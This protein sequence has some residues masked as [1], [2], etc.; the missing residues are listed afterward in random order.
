MKKKKNSG[1]ALGY[2]HGFSKTEQERLVNQAKLL[3]RFVFTPM[4][5]FKAQSHVI[6]VGCGVGA[7]TEILMRRFPHLKVTAIDAS[8]T[9]IQTAKLRLKNSTLK[10]HVSFFKEDALNLRFENQAFDGAFICWLLEHVSDP[11]GILK[12]A[13]RVLKPGGKIFCNEVHNATFY[14]HPYSPATL[15][16]WFQ[17][18]DLQWT[19]KGDPFVGAKLGDYLLK[20]GFRDIE[21]SIRSLHFD[22]RDPKERAVFID[23]WTNLLLSAAPGLEKAKRVDSKQIAEVRKELKALKQDKNSVF[24]YSFVQAV[25]YSNKAGY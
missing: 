13:E 2:V 3:E 8:E 18:N 24:F 20:S 6:E 1:L 9:Q 14:V 19:M 16:Y 11:V 12:E 15:Q 10:N 21:T 7:Q 22:S 25:G 17:F 5:D 4:A 23:Y